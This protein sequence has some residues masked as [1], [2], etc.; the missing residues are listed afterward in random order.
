VVATCR[1]PAR[2]AELLE[3]LAHYGKERLTLLRLD[4]LDE[5]TVTAAAQVVEQRFGRCDLLI[6]SSGVLHI[7]GELQPGALPQ[8]QR[9]AAHGAARS[10]IRPALRRDGVGGVERRVD[11][12]RLP[13]E[14]HRCV[15]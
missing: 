15:F 9:R 4:V 6:N 13:S 10:R 3:L 2:A 11:D 1:D 7:P 12:V 5:A 14:C 8:R